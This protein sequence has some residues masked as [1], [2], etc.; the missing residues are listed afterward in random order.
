[1]HRLVVKD[2][3]VTMYNESNETK[4]IYKNFIVE[5][6]DEAKFEENENRSAFDER[7]PKTLSK[8]KS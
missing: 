6:E 1:M 7:V 5:E 8:F 4:D 2:L 3:T